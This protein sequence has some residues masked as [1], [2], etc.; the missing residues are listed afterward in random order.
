MLD[1]RR[2]IAGAVALVIIAGGGWWMFGRGDGGAG[3]VTIETEAAAPADV[4]RIVGDWC[5]PPDAR[6]TL[7]ETERP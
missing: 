6:S 1:N 3:E 5:P 4:R 2:W 7:L